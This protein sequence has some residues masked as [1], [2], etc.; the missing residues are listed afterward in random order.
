MIRRLTLRNFQKHRKKVLEFDPHITTITGPSDAGKSSCLR[1]LRWLCTN[2]PQGKSII[3]KGASYAEVVLELGDHVIVRHVGDENTYTLDGNRYVSFGTGVPEDIVRVLNLSGVSFQSQHDPLYGFSLSSGDLAK[4]LNEVV[5]LDLIDQTTANL[6]SDLRQARASETV[7][8]QRL[9]IAKEEVETLAWVR[10]AV[11]DLGKIDLAKE[12]LASNQEKRLKLASLIS[13]W[14]KYQ[15]RY[16]NAVEA[17]SD[18]V[19][20]LSALQRLERLKG[21]GDRL[22]DLIKQGQESQQMGEPI[23]I[24]EVKIIEQWVLKVQRGREAADKLRGLIREMQQCE[25]RSVVLERKK[26]E[27]ERLLRKA[28]KGRCPTCGQSLHPKT[29]CA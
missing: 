4:A 25:D 19:N 13:D 23:P 21:R 12:V 17:K 1:A 20:L 3:R 28:T 10:E 24:K 9:K 2:R 15:R 27:A 5:N 18:A 14:R 29:L 11:G 8:R 7:C 26:A 6:A 22:R 16:Q